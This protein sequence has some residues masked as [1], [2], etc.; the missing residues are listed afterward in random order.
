MLTEVK[1]TVVDRI[2]CFLFGKGNNPLTY[3][4]DENMRV[5]VTMHHRKGRR[6]LFKIHGEGTVFYTEKS[7]KEIEL[8]QQSLKDLLAKA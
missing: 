5:I 2:F 1:T 6:F 3:S 8:L 4:I 7:A